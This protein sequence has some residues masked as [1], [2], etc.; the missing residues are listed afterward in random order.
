MKVTVDESFPGEFDQHPS[1]LEQKVSKAAKASLKAILD[2]ECDAVTCG[3][4][5]AGH[6][7]EP[8]IK[9]GRKGGEVQ[10]VEDMTQRLNELYKARM[11]SLNKAIRKAVKDA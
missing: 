10:A 7:T 11:D 4:T 2:G 9:A 1:K 5:H 3:H 6:T 8:L